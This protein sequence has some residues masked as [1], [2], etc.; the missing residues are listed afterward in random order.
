MTKNGIK[1]PATNNQAEGA[2]Q[3][4]KDSLQ[5]I[6]KRDIEIQVCKIFLQYRTTQHTTTGLSPVELLM[7]KKTDNKT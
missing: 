2:V 6:Q 1:H 4:F 3:S 7:K 5:K